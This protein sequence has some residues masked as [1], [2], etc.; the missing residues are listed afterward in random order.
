MGKRWEKPDAQF[1]KWL[2]AGLINTSIHLFKTY[3]HT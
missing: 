1:K 3:T 2:P